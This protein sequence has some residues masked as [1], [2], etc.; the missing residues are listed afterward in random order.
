MSR[1]YHRNNMQDLFSSLKYGNKQ[2]LDE[3][4]KN[5]G[6]INVVD[7]DGKSLLM[8]GLLEKNIERSQHLIE[9]GCNV[10]LS[11]KNG[12][13]PLHAACQIKS[14]DMVE[15][16]IKHGANIRYKTDIGRTPLMQAIIS[17]SCEIVQKL[18]MLGSDVNVLDHTGNTPLQISLLMERHD[19]ADMLV[20]Q[21]GINLSMSF[22]CRMDEHFHGITEYLLLNGANPFEESQTGYQRKAFFQAM[23]DLEIV[24]SQV[25]STS[26]EQVYHDIFTEYG[27]STASYTKN[28]ILQEI[29]YCKPI[30]RLFEIE[31][32][33]QINIDRTVNRILNK[34]LSMLRI[35]TSLGLIFPVRHD[36]WQCD[37]DNERLV[38]ILKQ[39]KANGE[40]WSKLRNLQTSPPSLKQ[41]CRTVVRA[42]LNF[43]V[44][45]KANKLPLP[46][47]I[48]SYL[49]FPELK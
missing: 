21:K 7:E 10:N 15:L 47:Q 29:L 42:Q 8:H 43:G 27:L 35:L 34:F 17:G 49:C 2:L 45:F 20:K 25:V 38:D 18:L 48:K 22:R 46:D 16:L 3:Y 32:T 28:K 24:S 11:T 44:T 23:F 31:H 12:F 37:C 14:T 1:L 6:D 9:L 30:C 26:F 40:F 19:I 36:I 5:G 33:L 13:S 41:Q 4:K 39:L